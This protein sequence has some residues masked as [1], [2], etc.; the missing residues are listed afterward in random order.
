MIKNH[1]VAALL[2][3]NQGHLSMVAAFPST[4]LQ[5]PQQGR[6]EFSLMCEG[7]CPGLLWKRASP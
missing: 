7:M 3:D 4:K 6:F 2:D 5:T 1:F